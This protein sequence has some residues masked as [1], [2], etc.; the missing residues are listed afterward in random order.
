MKPRPAQTGGAASVLRT[1]PRLQIP[2]GWSVALATCIFGVYLLLT[3]S[4]SGDKDASEFAVILATGGV[5]HPTGYPIYTLLGHCCVL[6]LH[7]CGLGWPHAANIF[8]AVGGGLAL[9]LYHRLALHVLAPEPGLSRGVCFGIAAFPAL[10]LGLNPVWID[11]CTVV[12]V[13]S[14]HLAWVCGVALVFVRLIG[15]LETSDPHSPGLGGQMAAWGLVC[16]LGGAHHATAVFF[17]AGLTAAL[18]WALVRAG[19]FRWWVPLVW[20][21]AGLLPLSSYGYLYYR[22]GHPG[23]AVIWPTLEPT[24]RSVLDH[25]TARTYR[26]FL[27]RWS[28]EASQLSSLSRGIYPF[29]WPGLALLAAWGFAARDFV[30]RVALWGVFFSALAQLVFIYHYGVTD[31][32]PYFLP[33]LAMT[34]LPLVPA[35]RSVL[36]RIESRRF[37]SAL[38][39]TVAVVVLV[40]LGVPGIRSARETQRSLAQ[41]DDLLHTIWLRIPSEQGIVLWPNGNYFRLK[42][43]Q[44]FRREKPGLDVYHTGVLCEEYPRRQFQKKYGFDPLAGATSEH[45][46]QPVNPDFVLGQQSSERDRHGFALIH[47]TIVMKASVPVIGFDPP[48]GLRLYGRTTSP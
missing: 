34:L 48:Y 10:V 3:P 5:L 22:A 26:E 30:R 13:H 35:S 24:L 47:E 23:H 25:A 42:E 41:I 37:G 29:L 4:V 2:L 6:L 16:G 14:W 39:G 1:A 17:A 20:F 38:T 27:G 11:A 19:R 33:C 36:R 9:I 8:A 21:T 28:P 43:Y 7:A 32:A 45:M 18:T 44:V 40:L 12:E 46:A 15:L 31:P